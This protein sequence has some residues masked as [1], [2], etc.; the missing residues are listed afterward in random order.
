M[1]RLRGRHEADRLFRATRGGFPPTASPMRNDP[2]SVERIA[3][4]Q[5][6]ADRKAPAFQSVLAV[7]VSIL[8]DVRAAEAGVV[9]AAISLAHR[10]KVIEMLSETDGAL[11]ALC[12]LAI[13]PPVRPD[14]EEDGESGESW[15]FALA[16]ATHV[17]ETGIDRIASLVGSQPRGSAVRDLVSAV[18]RLM[19]AHHSLLL[20]EAGRWIEG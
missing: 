15:W 2:D 6:A 7:V 17:L 9:E 20:D 12:A 10:E 11:T 5:L 8:E 3:R 18:V 1:S 14:R 13:R 16:E 4:L 19:R